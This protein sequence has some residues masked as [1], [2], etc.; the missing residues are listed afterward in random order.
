MGVNSHVPNALIHTRPTTALEA[1]FSLQFQMAI[2][3]LER[4]AGIAQF[5]DAKVQDPRTQLL[6]ERVHVHVDPEIE[7]L[8]YNEMRMTVQITL[9]DGRKLA[10]FADAAK[11][12]PKKPMSRAD[13]RE[14]F[15]DCAALVIAVPEAESALEHLWAIRQI[16]RVADLTP[17]LVGTA[18]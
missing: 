10:G 3:V 2:G 18:P 8:G 7:A 15:L 17:M 12:H 6:M 14:K 13:L 4:R 11:G 1:K 5:A 16:D 9:R